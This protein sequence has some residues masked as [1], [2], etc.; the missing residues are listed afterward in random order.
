[1]KLRIIT[2]LGGENVFFI[3]KRQCSIYYIL[4]LDP[5]P[6]TLL[7]LSKRFTSIQSL[8]SAINEKV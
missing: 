5:I 2:L 4:N 6:L 1:V 3:I 7:N 8:I